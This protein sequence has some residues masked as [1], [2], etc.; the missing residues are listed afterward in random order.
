MRPVLKD[1]TLYLGDNG[2]CYCGE[3]S[4]TIARYTGRDLS[5]QRVFA[6]TPEMAREIGRIVKCEQP[7]CDRI[8]SLLVMPA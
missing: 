4:G 8:R 5:G 1:A 3:H 6:I 7:G 2:A